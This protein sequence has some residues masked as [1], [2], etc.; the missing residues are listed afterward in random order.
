M[1]VTNFFKKQATHYRL[2]DDLHD[3]LIL[4]SDL[5]E[6]LELLD[7]SSFGLSTDCVIAIATN[8]N[9]NEVVYK[10][11]DI[12]NPSK[13]LGGSLNVTF[14]GTWSRNLGLNVVL[15]DNKIQRRSNLN[16]MKLRASFIVSLNLCQILVFKM[17]I[18]VTFSQ[19]LSHQT[20]IQLR[21]WTK[22]QTIRQSPCKN[23]D[24]KV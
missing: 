5:D 22:N 4:G 6:V 9:T 19:V 17:V 2:Y 8:N 14:F 10:L 16:R 15:T 24:L 12:Y 18:F 11:Y 23:M 7:D 20:K 3:W 1:V 21:T 13:N